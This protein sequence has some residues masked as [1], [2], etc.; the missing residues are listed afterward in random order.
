MTTPEPTAATDP[1]LALLRHTV[2]TVAYRGGK[3]LRGCPVGFAGFRASPTTRTP[4]EIVAHLGDLL[5]WSL[6]M[7]EGRQEWKPAPPGEWEAEVARFFAA[8]GAFDERLAAGGGLPAAFP[9]ETL[10][11]GPIADALTHVGQLAL[12]RRMAGAPV[13]GE[14]YVR[15]EIVA[16]RVG[17]EQAA[18]NREF[19]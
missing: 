6:S 9:A 10:F 2:A 7:V 5:A 1:R 17:P 3:T 13:R 15:A 14:N 11:Q 19:D 12:L 8:L 16:G 4:L 18:P